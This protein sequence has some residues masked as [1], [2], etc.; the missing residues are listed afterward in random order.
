M[1]VHVQ[2]TEHIYLPRN[3]YSSYNYYD[4]VAVHK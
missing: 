4:I 2:Y 3:T 1:R